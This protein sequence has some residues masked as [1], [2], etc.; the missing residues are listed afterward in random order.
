MPTIEVHEK[1]GRIWARHLDE[2]GVVLVDG[3]TRIR[4]VRDD[5]IE[6]FRKLIRKA[7]AGML[8][9]KRNGD[10]VF[11]EPGQG[12]PGKKVIRL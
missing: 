4:L 9:C 6:D 1:D 7:E 2:R 8:R 5:K 3:P 10:R 12:A 11:V